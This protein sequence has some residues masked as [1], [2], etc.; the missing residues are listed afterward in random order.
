[1]GKFSRNQVASTHQ[2]RQ[3]LH[4]GFLLDVMCKSQKEMPMAWIDVVSTLNARWWGDAV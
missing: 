2:L 3:A 1:M 4:S